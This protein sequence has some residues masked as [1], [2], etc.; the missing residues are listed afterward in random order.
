M[1]NLRDEVKKIKDLKK[2]EITNFAEN[3]YNQAKNNI[4][5]KIKEDANK[6]CNISTTEIILSNDVLSCLRSSRDIKE[7]F[8]SEF[9]RLAKT[10]DIFTVI[11]TVF[12]ENSFLIS[13]QL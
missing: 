1:E 10:E 11:N 7:F 4:I 8:S 12:H 9:T 2:T 3:I 13:C 5:A 6:L